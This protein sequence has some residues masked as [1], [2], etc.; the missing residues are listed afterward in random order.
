M[1]S[2]EEKRRSGVVAGPERIRTFRF[3]IQ[4]QLPESGLA[5]RDLSVRRWSAAIGFRV[6]QVPMRNESGAQPKNRMSQV[7]TRAR[8]GV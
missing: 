8:P 3:L 5:G 6:S 7:P 2:A 4:S 1:R